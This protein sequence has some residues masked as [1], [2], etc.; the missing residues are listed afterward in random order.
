MKF[1]AHRTLGTPVPATPAV[2]RQRLQGCVL[3]TAVRAWQSPARQVEPLTVNEARIVTRS[4][5]VSARTRLPHR[6][7][8]RSPQRLIRA[9]FGLT[10]STQMY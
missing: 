4:T 10:V 7:L 1:L 9:P 5:R 2:V 6:S 8:R 3:P